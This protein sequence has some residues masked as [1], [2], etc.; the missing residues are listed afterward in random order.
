MWPKWDP[1][2][3]WAP[4]R[5]DPR[6]PAIRPHDVGMKWKA[7]P[8]LRM[9]TVMIWMALFIIMVAW[10][11]ALTQ[12]QMPHRAVMDANVLSHLMVVPLLA[13]AWHRRMWLTFLIGLVS[14][15]ASI[16]YHVAAEVSDTYASTDVICAMTLTVWIA[17]L[18]VYWAA[19]LGV[20]HTRWGWRAWGWTEGERAS[21]GLW[22][23]LTLAMGGVALGAFWLPG[24][25][26]GATPVKDALHPMWHV[27]A[28]TAA[29]L[30]TA[31]S[32]MPL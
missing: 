30:A 3:A 22:L 26:T 19:H 6:Y 29:G 11:L 13:L 16:G 2:S 23:G 25:M 1:D 31:F 27:A 4:S 14:T 8:L 17:L 7:S 32:P 5:S 24:D 12:G 21:S 10:M 18:G 9:F 15:V 28:F 20:S